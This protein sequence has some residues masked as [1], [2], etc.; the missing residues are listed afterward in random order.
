MNENDKKEK[1]GDTNK[2]RSKNKKVLE[3]AE[4]G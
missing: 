4:E 3:N 1:E 2:E